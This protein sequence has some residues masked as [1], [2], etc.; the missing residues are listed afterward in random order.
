MYGHSRELDPTTITVVA[1]ISKSKSVFAIFIADVYISFRFY[2]IINGF[3]QGCDF[4]Q[5][6]RDIENVLMEVDKALIEWNRITQPVVA[7]FI[8]KDLC[9]NSD[10]LGNLTELLVCIIYINLSMYFESVYQQIIY[11]VPHVINK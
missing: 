9:E 6:Q 8:P 3:N 2:K 7:C 5:R 11:N 4:Q 10:F 1:L